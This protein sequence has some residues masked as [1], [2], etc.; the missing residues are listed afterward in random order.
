MT[1]NHQTIVAED[2]SNATSTAGAA[3]KKVETIDEYLQL[4]ALREENRAELN[5]LFGRL[6]GRCALVCLR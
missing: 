6:R 3:K 5:E 4:S 2:N 1:K